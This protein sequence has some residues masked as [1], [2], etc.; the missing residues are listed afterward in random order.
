MEARAQ[1]EAGRKPDVTVA[2]YVARYIEEN[3]GSVEATTVSGYR[4]LLSRSIAPY[5]GGTELRALDPDAVAAWVADLSRAKSKATA[6]KA[7]VLLRGALMVAVRRGLIPSN[8][9]DTVKKPKA[10]KGE[11][12]ALGEAERGRV[13]AYVDIQPDDPVSLAI[14][15]A[16]Y[17][18]MREAEICGLRWRNVDLERKTLRVVESLGKARKDDIK[19]FGEVTEVFSGVYLKRPKNSGSVRTVSYPEGVARALKARRAS[20]MAECMAAGVPFG[21][22]MFVCGTVEGK[23]M[24][25]HNLWRRWNGLVT[26]MGLVGTQGKTPTF[27]DLRHTYATA[28]IANGIDVKTVSNQMGHSNAA[29][30]LNTYASVDPDAARR[31]ADRMGEALEA[32]AMR[33][34]SMGG[35]VELG[36]TGTDI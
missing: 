30:T 1:A 36:R 3:A 13:A 32:D 29:M 31:A 17:T 18:G 22:S 15:L 14:R 24:H 28:A 27:H 33:A 11:P 9:T 8:P 35:V 20:M 5:I 12:N 4:T 16:L 2:E 19:R 6:T 10:E 25:P 21:E 34:V 23:P 7:F 26:A